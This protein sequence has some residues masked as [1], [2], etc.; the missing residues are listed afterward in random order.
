[1]SFLN[2]NVLS[3]SSYIAS[4]SCEVF[5]HAIHNLKPTI[6]ILLIFMT[7]LTAKSFLHLKKINGSFF[8][9]YT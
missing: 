4:Y 6:K 9:F 8:L 3:T 2:T 1:M 7:T 5:G